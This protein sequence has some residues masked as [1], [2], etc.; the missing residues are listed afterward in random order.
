MRENTRNNKGTPAP[1]SSSRPF[2]RLRARAHTATNGAYIQCR[3]PQ[4]D[5]WV[6]LP[7]PVA[8]SGY[9]LEL[10]ESLAMLA[11]LATQASKLLPAGPRRC[12]RRCC[13]NETMRM[14]P[15]DCSTRQPINCLPFI[16]LTRRGGMAQKRIYLRLLSRNGKS[17]AVDL[18]LSGG[19]AHLAWF[20]LTHR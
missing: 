7:G 17:D 6:G 18:Q 11:M 10:P 1:N 5:S 16:D 9:E 3:P 12:G 14:E 2:R 19:G 13:R 4:C 15:H 8:G 20:Q